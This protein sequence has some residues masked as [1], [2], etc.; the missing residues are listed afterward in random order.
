MLESMHPFWKQQSELARLVEVQRALN[1]TDLSPGASEYQPLDEEMVQ[2]DQTIQALKL[3]QK[4]VSHNPEHSQRLGELLD[5]VQKFREDL[6]TQTPEQSFERSIILRR[7]LFWLPPSMLR[8]GDSEITALAIISQFFAVGITLD[9]FFPKMGGAYLGSLSVGPIEEMYRIV[10]AHSATDPFSAD[11]RL[12]P[13]LMDFPRRVV[14]QY[15]SRLPWSPGGSIVEHYSP[16]PSS[17]YPHALH[18]YP[19]ASSSS[20]ISASPSHAAYTPPLQ[21]PSAVTVAGSPFHVSDG[22]YIT[23]APSHHSLYPPSPQLQLDTSDAQLG[24]PGLGHHAGSIPPSSA[25]TPPYAD[26][27]LCADIPRADGTLGLNMI[28]PHSQ[29]HSFEV[30]GL[31]EPESCWT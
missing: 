15:R 2:L 25:F 11:L 29:T 24:L 17:P 26:D 19:L 16:G 28:Y 27:I 13:T 4:R 14:A 12:A 7:W 31:V 5:F 18:D 23:V 3:T 8:G 20:P 10:V 6:P 9:R 22:G 1:I 21:S 30:P